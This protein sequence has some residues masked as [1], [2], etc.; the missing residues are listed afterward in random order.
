MVGSAN[1]LPDNAVVALGLWY[2]LLWVR[3]IHT[4]AIF[5]CKWIHELAVLIVTSDFGNM[6]ICGSLVKS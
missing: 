4:N 2:M 6:E 3:V 5:I 1:A